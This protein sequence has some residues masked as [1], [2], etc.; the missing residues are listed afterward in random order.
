ML[1]TCDRNASPVAGSLAFPFVL[2][3]TLRTYYSCELVI[4]TSKT[5]TVLTLGGGGL[6]L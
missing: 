6:E 4:R 2:N 3:S 1:H 5:Q